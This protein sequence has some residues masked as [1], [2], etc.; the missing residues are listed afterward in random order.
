MTCAL[1]ANQVIGGIRDMISVG[2]CP[3]DVSASKRP[4]AHWVELLDA[5]GVPCGPIY[6]M[7]EMF[8]DPQVKHLGV[9]ADVVAPMDGPQRLLA[10]PLNFSDARKSIPRSAELTAPH[11]SDVLQWLGYSPAEIAELAT[12]RV[13]D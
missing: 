10:S 5:A 12:K 13:I 3:C 8:E 6:D 4:T 9:A 11:T 2:K 7:A 1:T